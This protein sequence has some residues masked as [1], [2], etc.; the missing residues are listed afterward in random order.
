[1]LST[2]ILGLCHH[3]FAWAWQGLKNRDLFLLLFA[4][5]AMAIPLAIGPLRWWLLW[6][7]ESRVCYRFD[8]TGISLVDGVFCRRE[9]I[10]WESLS[11]DCVVMQPNPAGRSDL[12]L[13]ARVLPP[14]P[15]SWWRLR[16]PQFSLAP[17]DPLL[18]LND[19]APTR[20]LRDVPDADKVRQ[21]FMDWKRW[22][23][24]QRKNTS[25]C[26]SL[27]QVQA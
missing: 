8:E 3:G 6:R 18:V 14:L 10:P 26:A 22:D 24:A 27:D 15:T 20:T 23:R 19:E 7:A 17:R 12:L 16:L 25:A 9:L 11:D 2:V 4:L 13:K 5:P 1:L 21:N